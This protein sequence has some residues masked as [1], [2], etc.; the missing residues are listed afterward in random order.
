MYIHIYKY[1]DIYIRVVYIY[2]N[3]SLASSMHCVFLCFQVDLLDGG[4][5]GGGS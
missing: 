2:A 4:G 5:G 1:S 3:I